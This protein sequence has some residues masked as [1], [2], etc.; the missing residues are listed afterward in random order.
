MTVGKK[1][2]HSDHDKALTILLDKARS[3]NVQLSYEKLQYKKDEVDFFGETYITNSCKS[4][5]SKVSAITTMPGPTCKEQ[6]QLFIGMINYL[7]NFSVQ[8]SELVE[9]IG[10]LSKEKVPFNWGPEYQSAFDLMK[11]EIASVSVLVYYNPKE[12]IV[13]QTDASIKGLGTCLLQDEKLVYFTGKASTDAQNGYVAI[14]L[15]S[16]AVVW[17]WR[18][19]NTSCTKATSSWRLIRNFDK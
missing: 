10:E 8:L 2:N 7:S 15:E 9:P 18:G 13:L 3:C 5:Q 4:A 16:L 17:A 12:Q 14:E 6:V 11:K 19:F 1:H